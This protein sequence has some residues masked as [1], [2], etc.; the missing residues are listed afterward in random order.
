MWGVARA[1]LARTAASLSRSTEVTQSPVLP[2]GSSTAPSRPN[3]P[4]MI[5]APSAAAASATRRNEAMSMSA[6][7]PQ[8]FGWRIRAKPSA[9]FHRIATGS[10]PKAT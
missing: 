7:G 3:R 4:A 8:S 9:R 5:E 6:A 2:L 1:R 10:F